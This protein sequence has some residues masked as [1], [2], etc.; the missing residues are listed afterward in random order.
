MVL[1]GSIIVPVTVSKAAPCAFEP[2][3][4]TRK[5]GAAFGKQAANELIIGRRFGFVFSAKLPRCRTVWANR[6]TCAGRNG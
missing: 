6:E 5:A 1:K 4:R 2:R 3:V